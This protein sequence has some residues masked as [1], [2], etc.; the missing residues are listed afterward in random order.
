MLNNI[1]LT[2]V[3]AHEPLDLFIKSANTFKRIIENESNG[4]IKINVITREQFHEKNHD[5]KDD[6]FYRY[7]KNNEFQMAQFPSGILGRRYADFFAF[8]LPFLFRDHEHARKVLDGRI[9]QFLLE[10]LSEK[11]DVQGLA[12]TY[13]GGFRVIVS[14]TPVKKLED[15][16]G[17]TLS[18]AE[19][20]VVKET[21][22]LLGAKVVL[23]EDGFDLHSH[24]EREPNIKFDG[25]ETTLVRYEKIK[26]LM[27]YITNSKHSLFLTTIV[28]SNQFWNTLSEEDKILFQT[29]AKKSALEER[30]TTI[31]D[32]E[33]F[34]NNSKQ[35]CKGFYQ[36]DD[37]QLERMKILTSSVYKSNFVKN[38]ISPA[39]VKKIVNT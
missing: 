16:T 25:G 33:E 31:Q 27:P 24:F 37:E 38:H 8:D 30:T 4:R 36:L 32:T 13:S 3:V 11:S 9:G 22:E 14:E 7:L 19:S 20:P 17:M 29:A 23:D 26:T 10:K 1:E 2:W 18:C 35:H 6:G 12:F 15:I 21:Y 39:L 28:I 5:S 34:I